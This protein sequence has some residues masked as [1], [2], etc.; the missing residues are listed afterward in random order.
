MKYSIVNFP[1]DINKYCRLCRQFLD[2]TNCSP[3][4]L[5]H[6]DYICNSCD[7]Q[8]RLEYGRKYIV[9]TSINGKD[10]NLKGDKRKY[11]VGGFCEL[12]GK[13]P[14]TYLVYHHWD[15]KDLSKG[16]WICNGMKCHGLVEGIDSHGIAIV[17]KYLNFKK[18]FHN[19]RRK[20][21]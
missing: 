3:Y 20:V 18:S 4:R 12:C 21:K 2:S 11:P 13:T 14:K 9:Q 19:K 7:K 17:K 8:F 16:I 6:S 15:D 5:S 10:M 1:S